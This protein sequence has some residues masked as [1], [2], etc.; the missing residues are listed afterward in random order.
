MSF[1]NGQQ[2]QAVLQQISQG[3]VAGLFLAA[4][5]SLCPQCEQWITKI[6]DWLQK[7]SALAI[8]GCHM[9]MAIA[10]DMANTALSATNNKCINLAAATNN[11]TDVFAAQQ[12][13]CNGGSATATYLKNVWSNAFGTG[14]GSTSPTT[15]NEC[16]AMQSVYGSG[17]TTWALLN[18][19]SA[20]Q[21][22]PY[23]SILLMSYMGT[24]S[25]NK[26]TT[27]NPSGV[28]GFHEP[29]INADQLVHV[30]MCGT[31]PSSWTTPT[32]IASLGGS[33]GAQMYSVL[34]GIQNACNKQYGTGTTG[35]G[36]QLLYCATDT[37]QINQTSAYL[38]ECAPGQTTGCTTAGTQSYSG[39]ANVKA[40]PLSNLDSIA[41]SNTPVIGTT[42]FEY[43][44]LNTL[45]EGVYDIKND[46]PIAKS[47]IQLINISP[48]PLYKALNIAAVYPSVS[49]QII[50]DN[51][52]ALGTIL[53]LAYLRHILTTMSKGSDGKTLCIPRGLYRAFSKSERELHVTIQQNFKNVDQLYQHEE[54]IIQSVKQVNQAILQRVYA[55]GLMS[56]SYR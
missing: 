13:T 28:Y 14:S 3:V 7:A 47:V 24:S 8:N 56:A 2:I 31:D 1:V 15:A 17:N 48:F 16:V 27:T 36:L 42:G 23:L 44:V 26:A 10:Q 35:G 5:G 41:F 6:E 51:A 49:A 43:D 22:E 55:Q 40:W 37:G 38:P 32:Y 12:T 33:S 54:Q 50:S 25:W 4:V 45:A 9:G 34:T 30:F 19:V 18:N 46:L 52:E 29:T 39:C 21:D 20:W 53:A 11:S